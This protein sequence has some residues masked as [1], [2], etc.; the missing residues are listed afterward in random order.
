MKQQITLQTICLLAAIALL[1]LGFQSRPR[2][3][4]G[5]FYKELNK[6]C[7]S[8]PS[9]FGLI[10]QERKTELQEIADYVVERHMKKQ[11]CKLL[12][13]C[14]SNSR[15][16]H[17]AQIWAQSASIFYGV[18]SVL[19]YSGGTEATRVHPNTVAALKRCGFVV[20]T[21]QAGDNPN[22]FVYAGDKV[23]LGVIYSKKYQAPINPKSAFLAAMVCSEADKSCPS[24]DGADVRVSLAYDDPKYYDGT[25]SQDLKYDERCRQI[26]RE[27]FFMMDQVKQKVILGLERQR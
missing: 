16:S 3:A 11:S 24:V 13:I 17:L 8:L 19:T 12:F 10:S 26:A 22:Y 15:R 23:P 5:S 21:S 4:G 14:T 6:Y 27:L 20:E 9:E 1:S 25:P 18:D 2:A 7:V